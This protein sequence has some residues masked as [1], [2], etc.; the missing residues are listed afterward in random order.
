[1]Y[2]LELLFKV[3]VTKIQEVKSTLTWVTNHDQWDSQVCKDSQDLWDSQELK[4]S[5]D[6]WDSQACKV[7]QD[8]W[9]TLT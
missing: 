9:G 5:H 2:F 1:M 8:L 3:E 6:Q 7:S 4:A